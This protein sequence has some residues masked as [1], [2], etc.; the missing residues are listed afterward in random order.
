MPTLLHRKPS[1]RPSQHP[2]IPIAFKAWRPDAAAFRYG[3]GDLPKQRKAG[4]CKKAK[5][6]ADQRAGR[7]QHSM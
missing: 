4:F 3:N 7:L 5:N 1:L 6:A 2:S